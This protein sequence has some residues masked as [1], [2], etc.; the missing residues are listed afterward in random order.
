MRLDRETIKFF[1]LQHPEPTFPL[2]IE[3]TKF[4]DNRDQM[5]RTTVRTI[6]LQVY[7]ID[8][9]PMQRFVLRHAS[10]SYFSQLAFHLRDLWFRLDAA[11]S[12][13]H[14]DRDLQTVQREHELQQDLLI[15]LSDVFELKSEQLNEVLADRLLN[16]AMLPLLLTGLMEVQSGAP[17]PA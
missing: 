17:R 13:A 8:D 3:A 1:F 5:V 16:C 9:Q 10:E 2:Y 14:T 7:R 4:F 15:Y 12:G 6:T 11:A